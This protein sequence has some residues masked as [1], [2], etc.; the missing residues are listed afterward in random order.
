MHLH[1]LA[2]IACNV[3]GLSLVALAVFQELVQGALV[4]NGRDVG[5]DDGALH[6][7]PEVLVA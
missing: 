2:A 4:C 5:T 7:V 3:D 6:R 1:S